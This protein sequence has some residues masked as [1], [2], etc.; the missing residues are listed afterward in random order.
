MSREDN[1]SVV[2]RIGADWRSLEKTGQEAFSHE[3]KHLI[4]SKAAREDKARRVTLA[5]EQERA[6]NAYGGLLES[7]PQPVVLEVGCEDCCVDP[8]EEDLDAIAP[9]AMLE[10]EAYMPQRPI[11]S[12]K[13]E[14]SRDS[15]KGRA[16]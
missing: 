3:N 7:Q 5:G 6:A 13:S 14:L 1:G 4:R 12:Q 2:K 8:A 16:A 15:A 10:F 11:A 9:E